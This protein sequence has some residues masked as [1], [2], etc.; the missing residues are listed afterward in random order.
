MVKPK[1][2]SLPENLLLGTA[3]AATQ[4]EGGDKNNSWYAWCE[5]GHI[6]DGST[7]LRANDHWN[8]WREDIELM[9]E[10]GHQTYRMGVEWSRIEPEQGK[11]DASAIEHYR[12][13]LK[14]LHEKG[15]KPLV[16]LHH[17][18]N[19]LWFERMGAF[20]NKQC[21]EL[22][23]KFVKFT[24]GSLYDLCSDYITIN[25]PNVYGTL[26][27]VFGEWPPGK[28]SLP[29]GL[30]VF[31]NLTLCHLYSYRDIHELY[32]EKGTAIEPRVSFANHLRVF[33]PMRR[34]N[35]ADRLGAGA[36][37]Y[38]FQDALTKAMFTGVLQF[39]I[40][41]GAPVGKGSFCDLIAINYYTRGAVKGVDNGTF[42]D[43]PKNDLGWEIYPQGLAA[44]MK[45]Q[46][47]KYKLPIWITENGTC[48][49]KDAFRASYIYDHLKAAVDSGLPLERYYHWTFMDN[50]EWL[51]GES[52]PFGIV[53]CDFAT[54]ERTVK[55][56]G[57]FYSKIIKNKGVTQKMVEEYL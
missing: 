29:S 2:F 41:I 50:F 20:Q 44:L 47:E 39:P 34:Q 9:A 26:G 30:H 35:L 1:P 55:R 7:T 21:V 36:L 17:F 3:T 46:Y 53:Q 12:E 51:E 13:E 18:T 48:D 56:S 23:R 45:E 4:I 32:K 38:L 16:T 42:S 52:A 25:E 57:E 43:V 49:K 27:F 15:I 14:L 8:R 33:H 22:F 19:P 31:K 5:Q 10:L 40:G 24:V 54:Q 37:S 6:H 11:F 28:K